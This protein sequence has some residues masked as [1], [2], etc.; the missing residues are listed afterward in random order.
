MTL[1]K[2]F[3]LIELLIVMAIIAT[4][5]AVATPVGVNALSQAKATNVS[6]NF[7]AIYQAVLQMLLLEQNPPTNGDILRYLVDKGYISTAPRGFEVVYTT[8]GGKGVYRIRY[9]E[10]DVDVL[11]VRAINNMV[12]LDET[13]KLIID[14]P[15]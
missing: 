13:G 1:R 3:T 8:V 9:L 7:Y 4:L 6:G 2:G 11:K 10:A 14:V 12:T 15:K 5:M